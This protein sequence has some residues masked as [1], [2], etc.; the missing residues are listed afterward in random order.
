MPLFPT[1]SLGLQLV[2][3]A[4]NEEEEQDAEQGGASASWSPSASL[5]LS[6]RSE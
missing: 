1:V 6:L 5:C 2:T 3:R 4:A